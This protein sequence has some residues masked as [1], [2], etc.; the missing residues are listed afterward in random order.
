MRRWIRATGV[1]ALA[2]AV[3]G[4]TNPTE[5]ATVTMGKGYD[6]GLG[7]GAAT[8]QVY[9][10]LPNEATC[11]G[12]KRLAVFGMLS[13]KSITRPVPAGIPIDIYAVIQRS[14]NYRTGVCR[15]NVTFTPIPSH[16]Y[17]VLQRSAVWESCKIEV[18][19]LA[20]NEMPADLKRDNSLECT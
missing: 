6:K 20:T 12:K 1:A 19:D 5:S 7:P 13:G 3:L 8:T 10:L 4:A 15:N 16:S 2:V 9:F 11:Q 17:A 14:E 18:T